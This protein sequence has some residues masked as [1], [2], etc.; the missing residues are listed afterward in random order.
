M[1]ERHPHSHEGSDRAR[2]FGFGI[3]LNVAYIIVEAAAGIL[4]NST[5]LLADAGHNLSDVLGLSLS[6]GATRL[7]KTP[8]TNDRTYGLRK[9][10]ILAPLLNALILLIAVGAIAVEAF[11]KIIQPES[12]GE[13]T[14]MIVAGVGVVIN[15]VTALLFVKGRK[16][17]INI[18]GAFLHMASDAGVSL[19]VVLTAL[20]IE[21]TGLSWLDPVVSLLIVT[22]IT[23]GAWRLLRDSFQL[24]VDAVPRDIPLDAVKQYLTGLEGVQAV[25]DLHVWAMSSTETALTAHLVMPS[26]NYADRDQFLDGVCNEL[27]N[28]FGIG[29]STIQIEKG[30]FECSLQR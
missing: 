15:G 14:M 12:V 25:H 6:W 1:S 23:I 27:H 5:A 13:T 26:Q 20:L 29:H 28:K 3:V 21:V 17:D 18:N 19:G 8:S 24:S 22:V 4:V 9:T 10:T 11:Q 16:E 2:P 7:A 30:T